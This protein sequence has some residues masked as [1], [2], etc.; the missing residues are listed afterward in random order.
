MTGP[1][2]DVGRIRAVLFDL[3]DTLINWR[4]AEHAALGDVAGQHLTPLGVE[5]GRAREVYAGVME[6]NFRA[7]RAN[8]RWWYIGERLTQIGRAHV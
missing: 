1:R 5:L 3:D 7:F 6:E 4:E 8:G 2:L